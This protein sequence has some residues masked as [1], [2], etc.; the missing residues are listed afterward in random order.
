MRI[1]NNIKDTVNT[2]YSISVP[3]F[4]LFIFVP[5]HQDKS[6]FVYKF[7]NKK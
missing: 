2:I 3:Q 4:D 5:W 1:N 7:S 6:S